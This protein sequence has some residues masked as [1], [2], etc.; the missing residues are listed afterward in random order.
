MRLRIWQ[1]PFRFRKI[2]LAN[3]LP[4]THSICHKSCWGPSFRAK[5]LDCGKTLVVFNTPVVSA[6]SNLKN[7]HKLLL[8]QRTPSEDLHRLDYVESIRSFLSLNSIFSR[9]TLRNFLSKQSKESF[10]KL[11]NNNYQNPR[12]LL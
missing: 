4:Q 10:F 6:L 8:H 11:F 1:V 12:K 9:V 7:L 5:L 2:D 3:F